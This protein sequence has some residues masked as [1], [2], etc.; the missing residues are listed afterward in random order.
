MYFDKDMFDIWRHEQTTSIVSI[1]E[2]MT[3]IMVS[4]FRDKARALRFTR[5]EYL[6]KDMLDK[7]CRH[8]KTLCVDISCTFHFGKIKVIK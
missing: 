7:A 6:D 5:F 1:D 3:R 4:V 8:T 2:R